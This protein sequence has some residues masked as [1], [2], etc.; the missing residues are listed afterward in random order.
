MIESLHDSVQ[1]RGVWK[2]ISCRPLDQNADSLRQTC[3]GTIPP[4]PP[5]RPCPPICW[6]STRKFIRLVPRNFV[7]NNFIF[8]NRK[9]LG[10]CEPPIPSDPS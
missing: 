7:R 3:S 5:I 8:A 4:C 10:V 6:C 9:N 1:G 2:N